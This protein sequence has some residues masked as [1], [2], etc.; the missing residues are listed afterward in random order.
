MVLHKLQP[1]GCWLQHT[2]VLALG[3]LL[4]KA[5]AKR[6]PAAAGHVELVEVHQRSRTTPS[7]TT[8]ALPGEPPESTLAPTKQGGTA[9]QCICGDRIVW[10]RKL[11][12]GDVKEQKEEEC[13]N[14]VCPYVNIPGLQVQAECAYVQDIKQLTAG[15]V[16][17]CQCGD[18]AAWVNRGFYGNVTQEKERECIESVCPRISPI[19]GLIYRA[20]CRFDSELFTLHEPLLPRLPHAQGG[21]LRQARV[22]GAVAVTALMAMSCEGGL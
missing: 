1:L 12:V 9:C 5:A 8:T 14:D 10:H 7:A 3:L 19:P 18:K 11:F 16:C 17:Y 2:V 21:V 20:K 22:A 13:K 15:T 6:G 4:Q